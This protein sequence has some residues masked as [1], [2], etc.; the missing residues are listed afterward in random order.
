MREIYLLNNGDSIKKI[1]FELGKENIKVAPDKLFGYKYAIIENGTDDISVVKNYLP[2][3]VYKVK[4]EDNYLDILAR[5]FKIDSNDNINADDI[6]ILKKPRSIRYVVSPLET[7]DKIAYKFGTKEE[8]IMIN[9]NLSTNKLF[10]GQIL[11]I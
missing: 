1:S 2:S 6:I 10:V 11:W 5:G 4:K 9:N 8:D 3:F 7:L